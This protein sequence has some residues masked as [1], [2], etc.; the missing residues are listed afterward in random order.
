[1]TV[2]HPFDLEQMKPTP[3]PDFCGLYVRD[4][5]ELITSLYRGMNDNVALKRWLEKEPDE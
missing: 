1:V 2:G 3:Q 4:V 5:E